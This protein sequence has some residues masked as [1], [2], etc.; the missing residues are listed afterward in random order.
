M[1]ITIEVACDGC[2]RGWTLSQGEDPGP[3]MERDGWVQV[4]NK[5]FC[6]VCIAQGKATEQVELED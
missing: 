1:S 4:G 5:H 6:A 3:L 2:P